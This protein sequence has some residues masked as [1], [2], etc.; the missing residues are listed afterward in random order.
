[1]SGKPPLS[2]ASLG[3]IGFSLIAN[4]I[5]GGLL[6]FAAY[7]FLNWGWALPVGILV[8][9]VSGFFSMFRQLSQLQ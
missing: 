9:F 7:K 4:V 2:L 3:G 6:G 1:M 5:A 8:G